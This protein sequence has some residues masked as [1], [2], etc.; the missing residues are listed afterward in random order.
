[1]E[2]KPVLH[3]LL[4]VEQGLAETA[5]R[6]TKE[7]TKTLGTKQTLFTGMNKKHEIFNEEEQH[8]VQAP[9]I[10]EVESTVDEQLDYLN[11]ELVRY[12]DVTLQKEEAN[13][14][15]KADIIIDGTVIAPNIP[16]IVLLGME[17]KL[18]TLLAT[19][20]SIPTLDSAIAWEEDK[21]YAKAGVFRTKHATER[22]Q[23]V[24]TKKYITVSPATKEHP[25]Q[26]A[27][28]DVVDT[29]GK[30]VIT[31]FSGALSPYKKAERIQR[32]TTL[33][34]AV[35]SA[36]QRAN[37]TEVKSELIFGKA[38]VDYIKGN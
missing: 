6:V 18:A 16:A 17:K 30:Y 36:R 12:W 14:R 2:N 7:T 26:M 4:A 10:K 15:A 35:K 8:L 37:N 27:T 31:S 13:Q 21:G 1:M 23:T 9:D 29:V 5:N 22:Q 34:R 32:L 33:I 38:L 28:Q 24:T 25:A 19:F 20:N 11:T 3:E